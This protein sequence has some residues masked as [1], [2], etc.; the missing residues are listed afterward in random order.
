MNIFIFDNVID[1]QSD[2]QHHNDSYDDQSICHH[3]NDSYDDHCDQDD[4]DFHR[5]VKGFVQVKLE[6]VLTV[7]SAIQTH[8]FKGTRKK[9]LSILRPSG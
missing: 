9:N 6:S 4:N 5:L 3:D 1:D 7:T 8:D 2:H